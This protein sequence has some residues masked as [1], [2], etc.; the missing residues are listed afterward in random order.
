M[1]KLVKGLVQNS[2]EAKL[3]SVSSF[4]VINMT[5]LGGIENNQM[6]GELKKKG[7]RLMVVKNTLIRK[8]MVKLGMPVAADLFS[9]PCTV[10]FGGDSAV[11]IAKEFAEITKKFKTI[12]VKGAF[13]EGAKLDSVGAIALAK[14][15]NRAQLQSQIVVLFCSPGRK[16]ASALAAPAGVIAGCLKSL[17]DRSEKAEA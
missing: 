17:I 8:V 15:P 14:M 16:I 10:A 4:L 1:S 13:V 11:D 3:K 6:R 12:E 2:F 5:G 7:I 9:G